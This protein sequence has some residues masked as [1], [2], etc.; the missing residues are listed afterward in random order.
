MAD[1]LFKNRA[2]AGNLLCQKMKGVEWI[3]PLVLAIPRGGIVVGAIIAKKIKAEL[4]VI[5]ARKLRS[6]WSAEL[7]IGAVAEGGSSYLTP[8]GERIEKENKAYLEEEFRN[9]S[10]EV[11]LRVGWFRTL[12]EKSSW[13][14]RTVVITDD[15][16]A[17]GATFLAAIEVIKAE[18]PL[19][20]IAAVPVLPR[21][22]IKSLK[23]N[24]DK[25]FYLAS[26]TE[27]NA[28]GQFYEDFT[29]VEFHT[30]G[31]LLKE[32]QAMVLEYQKMRN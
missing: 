29:Q 11:E 9:Q 10:L 5:I 20:L 13:S 27:F 8:L 12:K 1:I 22:Q 3:N 31:E 24:C 16:I 2:Q 26:P 30:V 18:K 7:A 23:G 4:D 28:V 6:P 14:G 15:G 32:N 21:D 17:T 25:L 19:E